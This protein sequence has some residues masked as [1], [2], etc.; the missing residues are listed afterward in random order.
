MT[1]ETK[2]EIVIFSGLAAFL[3]VLWY[4]TRPGATTNG[5]PLA[6]MLSQLIGQGGGAT[7]PGATLPLIAATPGAQITYSVGN[8]LPAGLPG[9]ASCNTCAGT[10]SNTTQFGSTE[11]LATYLSQLSGG[12][13]ANELNAAV[14]GS[15]S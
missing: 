11:D 4:V 5:S 12:E 1:S 7:A 13:F 15:W 10:N 3:G 14:N 9:T 2:T 6:D 8:S